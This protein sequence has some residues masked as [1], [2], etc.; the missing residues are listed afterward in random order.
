MLL[1]RRLLKGGY[2]ERA[3]RSSQAVQFDNRRALSRRRGKQAGV[4]VVLDQAL[5]EMRQALVPA[6]PAR[7]QWSSADVLHVLE[8]M[9]GRAQA[10]PGM[11]PLPRWDGTDLN[12]P[13]E[14]DGALDWTGV[15]HILDV[16]GAARQLANLG[17]RR[18]L[19]VQRSDSSF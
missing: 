12:P 4:T 17:P 7:R 2:H 1:K 13:E 3:I 10:P 19:L 5:Q 18:L 11:H 6:P 9:A 15:A 16:P 14:S 8:G